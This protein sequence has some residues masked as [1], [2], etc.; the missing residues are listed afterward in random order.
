M[1]VSTVAERTRTYLEGMDRDEIFMGTVEDEL[2][3]GRKEE[4]VFF[5]QRA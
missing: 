2:Y 4:R 3:L 1:K 5:L